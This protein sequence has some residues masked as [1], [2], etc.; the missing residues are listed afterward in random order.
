MID[1]SLEGVDRASAIVRDVKGLAHA[2]RGERAMADLNEL[3][4]GVLRMAA[5]QLRVTAVVEKNY[6]LLPL[7]ACASQEVQQVFL[8]LVLNASQAITR[9]G[10]IRVRTEAQDRSV[11]VWIEDDGCGIEADLLERIFDPFFTTKPVGEGTGLGLGIAHEIVRK[12]GGEITIDSKPGR[13]TVFGVRLPVR[14]DTL[15][16]E[17]N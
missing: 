3:L 12:H 11:M 16:G 5:P 8:N 14:V 7:V 17:L 13:G 1:E 6:G 10:T 4:D 9:S 15:A 2:G